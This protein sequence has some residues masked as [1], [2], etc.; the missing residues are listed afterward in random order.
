M[1][2]QLKVYRT[3]A[4]FDDA[5]VAAPSQKAALAA[6]GSAKD[7][8]ARGDA[9]LV[10]DPALTAEPLA[11]PGVVIRRSRG[12]TAEQIASLP[13]NERRAATEDDAAPDRK[14]RPSAKPVKRASPK[15][16]RPPKPDR[17][18][19]IDAEAAVQAMDGQ[20]RDALRDLERREADLA[21]ERTALEQSQRDMLADARARYDE[22]KDGYDRAMK[23]WRDW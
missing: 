1:A 7:L 4:G 15:P 17:Q 23:R 16:D 18:D 22:E 11:R 10:D 6:W 20:H 9:E 19:L 5:Y 21:R 2:R 13:A 8:F 14:A 12:T 3:V